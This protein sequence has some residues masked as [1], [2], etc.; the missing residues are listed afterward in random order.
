MRKIYYIASLFL[1]LSMFL[2][3]NVEARNIMV[4]SKMNGIVEVDTTVSACD[5]FEWRGQVLTATG[6]Y[7]DTVFST[8]SGDDSVFVLSLTIWNSV[9]MVEEVTACDSYT[10]DGVM[11]IESTPKALCPAVTWLD[12]VPPASVTNLRFDK[13]KLENVL[14]WDAPVTNDPVQEAVRYVVY[15]FRE[16]DDID[17]TNP[18][19]IIRVTNQTSITL[20][21]LD[22]P[23]KQKMAR[24]PAMKYVVTA[25]DRC[26]NE[27]VPSEPVIVRF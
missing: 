7:R 8:A 20:P 16:N 22:I 5:S 17:I 19:A 9:S 11:Y 14:S 4:G 26:N 24:P 10:W 13:L 25:L 6:I 12:S 3:N 23:K 15:V 21:K 1:M 27:S 18:R 2:S